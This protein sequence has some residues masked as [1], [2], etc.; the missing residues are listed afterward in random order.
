V[1]RM[2]F[3]GSDEV[4]HLIFFIQVDQCCINHMAAAIDTVTQLLLGRI[5]RMV[6]VH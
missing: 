6:M 1:T 5:Q 4:L 3:D 2:V